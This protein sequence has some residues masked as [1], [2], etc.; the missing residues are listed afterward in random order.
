MAAARL[1][2]R[3]P[4]S[5]HRRNRHGDPLHGEH[6]AV[7][8]LHADLERAQRGV[9]PRDRVVGPIH[10]GDRAPQAFLAE[11]PVRRA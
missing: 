5:G 6:G 10:A 9:D 1:P 4:A 7:I 2:D 11:A 8:G 3:D